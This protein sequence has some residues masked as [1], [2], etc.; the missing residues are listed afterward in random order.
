MKMMNGQTGFSASRQQQ[1]TQ[2]KTSGPPARQ[3]DGSQITNDY[4][5]GLINHGQKN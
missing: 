4:L 1:N 3:G 5:N 2:F